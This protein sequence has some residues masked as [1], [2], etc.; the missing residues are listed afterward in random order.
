MPWLWNLKM[1]LYLGFITPKKFQRQ[2][3]CRF[4]CRTA[5]SE[6]IVPRLWG[7]A[8]TICS[9]CWKLLKFV[10]LN[11]RY[12]SS[13]VF[14]NVL[15]FVF[16][17]RSTLTVW[18]ETSTNHWRGRRI[19]ARTSSWIIIKSQVCG[20]KKIRF[21]DLKIKTVLHLTYNFLMFSALRNSIYQEREKSLNEFM[22]H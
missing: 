2:V 3:V 17:D 4:S 20:F 18:L 21:W 11:R 22:D 8:A 10:S 7:L 19:P 6:H 5:F 14:Y 9:E 13:Q 15:C 1:V 12:L 16:A